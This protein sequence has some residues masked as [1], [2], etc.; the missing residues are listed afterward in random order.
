[1]SQS[2]IDAIRSTLAQLVTCLESEN[3]DTII[4][5]QSEFSRAVD[6]AK[7]L[8]DQGKIQVDIKGLPAAMHIYA[9]QDL[10]DLIND[11]KTTPPSPRNSISSDG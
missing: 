7:S 6:T 9:T 1:M 10:P 5:A 8:L 3:M 4:T 2:S 11:K